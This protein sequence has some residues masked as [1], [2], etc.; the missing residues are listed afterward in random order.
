MPNKLDLGAM[1]RSRSIAVIGAAK[2]ITSLPGRP[3][4]FLKGFYQGEIYP[5][6]PNYSELNGLT[7][8]PS[9][10]SVQAE[11]DLAIVVI[12]AAK[13]PEVIRECAAKGVKAITVLSS[14]FAEQKGRSGKR[15]QKM[16]KEIALKGD[17]ALAGPNCAG[18]IGVQNGVVATF[19]SGLDRGSILQGPVSFVAQS[20]ALGSYLFAAAQDAGVGFDN[21]VST[22][23]EAVL[24]FHDFVSYFVKQETTR[25]I[26][27]YME[28]ARDGKA[29][30]TAALEALA[31]GKPLIILK[32]G[33]SKSGAKAASSHTGALAG[34]DKVYS[35]AFEQCGV[36]RARNVEDLFDL[37][38]IC[39]ATHYPRGP[40][41]ALMTISGGAGILMC[42]RC[43]DEGLQVAKLKNETKDALKQVL[44][45]FASVENPIDVTA[46]LVANPDL[47]LKPMEI[48]LAD[49]HV[50]SLV[51][52]LGLQ[53]S[54]G[55]RLASLIIEA[56]APTGKF[57]AVN[58]IA[59][60]PGAVQKLRENSIP[61][62][63]DPARGIRSLG[64]LVKYVQCRKLILSKNVA[65]RFESMPGSKKRTTG[66]GT[67]R[68]KLVQAQAII[69]LARQEKRKA[70]TEHEGKQILE[71]YGICTPKRR[72]AF[73]AKDAAKAAEA[74]GFPVAMKISS[75]D[76]LH[77]ADA[78]GVL[79]NIND[80]TEVKR[81]YEELLSSVSAKYPMAK[82]EG[83]LVEETI[84]QGIEVIV[85]A[86]QDNCFGT[87]V[88]FG[89]GGKL[90]EMLQDS[91]IRVG[92]LGRSVALLMIKSTKVFK[93]LTG[94]RG[95]KK[96]DIAAL[97]KVIVSAA[98]LAE[99]LSENLASLDI[100]PVLMLEKGKGAQA[101]DALFVLK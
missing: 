83:V 14:G 25:T 42:D 79:L 80:P 51:I 75:S 100:N 62:F 56:A 97:V 71:L 29:F 34:A 63:S 99:D 8:Y 44:P 16:L 94:Y 15:L 32:V 48:T 41:T 7:C 88:T 92:P 22:G 91:A 9:I 28:D 52:F 35:A 60:P 17:I 36:I 65:P 73:S 66:T 70:L 24:G 12:A 21:W 58:W 47:L 84:Q 82:L 61:V 26:I 95:D 46:E 19:I 53:S 55:L 6:N 39:G 96:R 78:G 11:I 30:Q 68:R 50:D 49:P 31:A 2:D 93:L 18:L 81:K 33:Q 37:A 45:S 20:G 67:S 3:L 27:G 40:R 90:V 5:V 13:V 43:E 77:K 74:I 38:S 98:R 59:A 101:V 54:N 1:F 86:K 64:A 85:G 76:I 72:L 4:H 57:I 10:S 87:V 69:Q 89:S 23:N